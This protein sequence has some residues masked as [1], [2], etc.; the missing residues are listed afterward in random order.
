MLPPRRKP[1]CEQTTDELRAR[2]TALRAMAE[3]ATTK[4]VQDSLCRLAVRYK[5]LADDRVSN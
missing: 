2:A 1:I 3:T 5:R 4:D